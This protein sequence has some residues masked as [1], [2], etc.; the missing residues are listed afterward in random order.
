MGIM[1]YNLHIRPI[2][3]YASPLW[4][5]ETPRYIQTLVRVQ[6]RC[7]RLVLALKALSDGD[8][9]QFLVKLNRGFFAKTLASE[10]LAL[11]TA[12]TQKTYGATKYRTVTESLRKL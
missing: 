12:T 11:K 8:L 5:I 10:N 3:T 4:V 6:N 7:L 1:L 2:L 9:Q